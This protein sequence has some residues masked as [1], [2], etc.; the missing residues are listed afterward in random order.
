MGKGSGSSLG[1]SQ[2]GGDVGGWRVAKDE[3]FDEG[4]YE[5]HYG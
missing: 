3:E 4:S 1:G 2:G 5:D